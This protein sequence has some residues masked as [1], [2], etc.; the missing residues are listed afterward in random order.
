MNRTDY[1]TK[2]TE[3]YLVIVV[4][5]EG[6]VSVEIICSKSIAKMHHLLSLYSFV[7]AMCVEELK[8]HEGVK[9]ND[10]YCLYLPKMKAFG[11]IR[12]PLT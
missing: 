7:H 5:A 1:R 9:E 3:G 6:R 11:G 2:A 8:L 12:A 10:V 4:R